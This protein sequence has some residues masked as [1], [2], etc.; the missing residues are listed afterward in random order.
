MKYPDCKICKALREA[1]PDTV[2]DE[3]INDYH[4]SKIGW[5][6][7][8]KEFQDKVLEIITMEE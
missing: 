7:F 3:V 5:E 4:E 2:S 8:P 6:G 1:L